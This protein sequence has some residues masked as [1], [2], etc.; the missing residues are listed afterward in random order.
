MKQGIFETAKVYNLKE[1]VDYSAGATVSK[2]ITQDE[3]GNLTLFAFDKGQELSEHTAPF[4]AIVQ[5]LHGKAKITINKQEHILSEGQ[6]IIMPAN[7]PH[8]LE[9]LEKFKMFLIMIKS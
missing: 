4:N 8:A 9:A 6:M 1:M 7:I 2:I 5:I 3:K